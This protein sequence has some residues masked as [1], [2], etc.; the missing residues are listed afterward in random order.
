M[1]AEPHTSGVPCTYIQTWYFREL[2]PRIRSVISVYDLFA[3][4]VKT[5]KMAG[6]CLS[7]MANS[8]FASQMPFIEAINESTMKMVVAYSGNDP[9]VE[10]PINQELLQAFRDSKELV[11]VL[12]DA[13]RLVFSCGH[14]CH[15]PNLDLLD[16][17][18]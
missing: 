4:K 10:P 15:F 2:R 8:D 11:S 9:I 12:K 6:T 5:G 1:E 16:A 13:T 18:G 14:R 7:L 3:L 17:R